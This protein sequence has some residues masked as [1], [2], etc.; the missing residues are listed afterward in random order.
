MATS[1]TH[2]V[3]AVFCHWDMPY[4]IENQWGLL[5]VFSCRAN[6]DEQVRLHEEYAARSED[7]KSLQCRCEVRS[8]TLDEYSR[9]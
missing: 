8:L 3:W 9:D 2:Q 1:E 4:L 6:A 7:H 5:G